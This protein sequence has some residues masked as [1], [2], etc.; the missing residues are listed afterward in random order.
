MF[1]NI[2]IFYAEELLAPRP[3]PKSEDQN[4]SAVDDCLVQGWWTYGMWKDFLG[5]Q[6]WL[7]FQSFFLLPDLCSYIV[8]IMCIH[9]DFYTTLQ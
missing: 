6:N 8:K 3:T 1:H 9:I 4:L 5:P 7:L 2:A